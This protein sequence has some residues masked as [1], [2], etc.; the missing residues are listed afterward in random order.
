MVDESAALAVPSVQVRRCQAWCLSA[1]GLCVADVVSVESTRD[2]SLAQGGWLR[3]QAGLVRQVKRPVC[4]Q[5]AAVVVW[6]E[7]L[8]QVEL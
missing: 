8:I 6:L 3:G 4:H 1:S 2:V 7:E 5:V